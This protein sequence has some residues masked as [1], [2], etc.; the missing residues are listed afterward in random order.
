MFIRPIQITKNKIGGTKMKLEIT[1][2][3]I[4]NSWWFDLGISFQ[5]TEFHHNKDYVFTLSIVFFSI[6]LRF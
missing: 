2:N 3:E 6:Y 4:E 5:K 1:L